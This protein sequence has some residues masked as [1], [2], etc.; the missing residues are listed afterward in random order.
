MT[1][2]GNY[3]SNSVSVPLPLNSQLSRD[4]ENQ[5]PISKVKAWQAKEPSLLTKPVSADEHIPNYSLI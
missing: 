1:L 4:H 3:H 5:G 2:V